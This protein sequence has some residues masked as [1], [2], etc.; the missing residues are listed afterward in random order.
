MR[1]P[2]LALVIASFA[3]GTSEFVIVGLL[4]ELAHDFSV[5]IPRAGFLVTAYALGVTFASPFVVMLVGRWRRDI[6]LISL[7][8]IFVVGNAICALAPG[9]D[10]MMAARVITALAHGAFFGIAS[11][12]AADL[13]PADKRAR[14]IALVFIG[15]TMA[16]VLGVPAGTALG[17]LAGWRATF[18]AVVAIGLIAI[19]AIWRLVPRDLQGGSAQLRNEIRILGRPQV[20]LAMLMA[21]LSSASLFSV[22]TYITPL[23]EQVSHIPAHWVSIALLVFGVG[24]SLGGWFGGHLAD[25]RPS[26]AA[27]LTLIGITAVLVLFRL[28]ATE[29]IASIVTLMIWG[30]AAFTLIAPLQTRVIDHASDAPNLAASVNQGAFNL[31]NAS[32]AWVGGAAIGLGMP[33]VALP[34]VGAGLASLA[35]G[36]AVWAFRLEKGSVPRHR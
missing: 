32:G 23:L 7:M 19:G 10:V 13:V 18:W 29:A 33:Y 9:F 14:A 22:L 2:L 16:N 28:T 21:V 1:L 26:V 34:L 11:V 12:V 27:L 5:S 24:L 36:T 6:A 35:L 30:T 4:P 3:I 15:L 25:R 8:G 31:G 17:Q 20:L